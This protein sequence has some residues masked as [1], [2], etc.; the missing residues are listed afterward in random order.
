MIRAGG[1]GPSDRTEAARSPAEIAA[2]I[3]DTRRRIGLTLDA[4][5]Q[6]LA[7]GRLLQRG[8]E[9][10][11]R[12]SSGGP[13]FRSDPIA[14]GLIGAGI[15]WLLAINSGLVRRRNRDAAS[16]T[17]STGAGD[18]EITAEAGA[19]AAEPIV[20]A[21]WFGENGRRAADF[22]ESNPLLIGLLGLGAGVALAALLPLSRREQKLVARTREDLWQRAEALGHE[23]AE[24]VRDL[25]RW[26]TAAPAKR[27]I[28][29]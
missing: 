28:P 1:A 19:P 25:G 20:A 14:L 5:A 9:M 3:D 13:G 10:T 16:G 6:R 4:L 29:E 22:I 27:H 23:A 24:R 18:G 15:A 12:L 11:S 8:L 2:K 26:P 21:E 7:P 17:D